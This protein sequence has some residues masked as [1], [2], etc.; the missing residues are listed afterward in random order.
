MLNRQQSSVMNEDQY[1]EIGRFIW[2]NYVPSH[3]QS[4]TVQGELL[5]ANEKLRDEAHRNGNIN[6]DKGHEILANYIKTTLLDSGDL[7]EEQE[8]QLIADIGVVLN[9]ER[10]YTEDDV[11]D[12]IERAIFDWYLKNKEP[13]P[14]EINPELH[15]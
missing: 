1:K 8:K 15:R 12:R 7:S 3:G 10:P 4:D 9:Y 2:Q 11:F 5:R 14:R 6:W 13:I